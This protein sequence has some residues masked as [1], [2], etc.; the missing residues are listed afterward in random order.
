VKRRKDDMDLCGCRDYD[1]TV[2]GGGKNFSLCF[3]F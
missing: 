3:E 2:F 1:M